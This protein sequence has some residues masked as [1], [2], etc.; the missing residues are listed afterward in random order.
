[1]NTEGENRERVD[2]NFFF[3][4]DEELHIILQKGHRGEVWASALKNHST[5]NPVVQAEVQKKLL[6]ERF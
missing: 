6:L 4:E 2:N 1:M 3:P 5:L